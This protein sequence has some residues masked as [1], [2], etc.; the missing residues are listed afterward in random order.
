MQTYL[1]YFDFYGV[2]DVNIYHDVVASTSG[3]V[4]ALTESQLGSLG[5]SLMNAKFSQQQENEADDCGYDFLVAQGR[6]PW[7][8]VMSFEK[9]M[10]LEGDSGS[11]QSYIQKMFSSHP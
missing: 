2:R 4:A 8:I 11:K 5:Q 1:Y 9:L 7:G 3:K 10:N 6:N